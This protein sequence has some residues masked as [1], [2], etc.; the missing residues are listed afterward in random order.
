[1]TVQRERIELEYFG[2]W[3]F[4]SVVKVAWG[5]EYANVEDAHISHDCSSRCRA[6]RVHVLND[7]SI[8][9][10][11]VVCDNGIY[12]LSLTVRSPLIDYS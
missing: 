12:D 1:M 8:C 3:S 10:R 5:S 6:N 2:V 9:C 7:L 4:D 11:L